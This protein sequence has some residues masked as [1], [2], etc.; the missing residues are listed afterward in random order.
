MAL[1]DRA[2]Q[3]DPEGALTLSYWA[4]IA[5]AAGRMQESRDV[6]AKVLSLIPSAADANMAMART[7]V[8]EEPEAAERFARTAEALI[9]T[10]DEMFLIGLASVYRRLGLES[11]ADRALDRYAAWAEDFGV[12]AAEWAQYYVLRGELDAAYQSLDE[13]IGRLERGETEL[14]YIALNGGE[15]AQQNVAL[16]A[17]RFQRL[18]ARLDEL[19]ASD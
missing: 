8:D 16:S 12:G 19:K 7:V 14:G 18:F 11:D 6:M 13:A 17:E 10:N 4:A 3:L 15:L 5:G 9:E 2:R 1:I